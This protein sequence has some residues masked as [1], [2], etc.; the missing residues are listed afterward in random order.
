MA[1]PGAQDIKVELRKGAL[2]MAL[3]WPL[4]AAAEFESWSAAML[5]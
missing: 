3:T 1:Q 5:K 4:S 2:S